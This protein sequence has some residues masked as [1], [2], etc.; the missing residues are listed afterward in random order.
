MDITVL[1]LD[2]DKN[3]VNLFISAVKEREGLKFDGQVAELIGIDRRILANWK[4]RNSL[5]VKFQ[6][7]YCERYELPLKK[8][9]KDIESSSI[10]KNSGYSN[11]EISSLEIEVE[12]LRMDKINLLEDKTLLQDEIIRLKDKIIKLMEDK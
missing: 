6:K 8:F 7:W 12:D 3:I 10:G 4:S 11:N 1:Y 5:P 9:H 2:M